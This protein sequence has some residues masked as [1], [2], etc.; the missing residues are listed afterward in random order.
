MSVKFEIMDE[1]G[2]RASSVL[3]INI[4]GADFPDPNSIELI[5]ELSS[6]ILEVVQAG[7]WE[8]VEPLKL[9]KP[10]A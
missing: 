9:R 5:Q 6:K 7:G 3:T 10:V 8:I 1:S 4:V 2:D